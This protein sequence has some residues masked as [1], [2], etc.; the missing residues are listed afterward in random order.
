MNAFITAVV[1]SVGAYVPPTSGEAP[2]GTDGI[3]TI[4]QWVIWGVSAIL[5]V[6]FITGLVQ[7]GKA[8]AQGGEAQVS[9]PLWPLLA[10]IVLGAASTIWAIL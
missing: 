10:S 1:G 9:A 3:S 7:A 4:I 5:F 2:P 8:R 6:Y